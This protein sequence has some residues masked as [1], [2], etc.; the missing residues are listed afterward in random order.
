MTRSE[1]RDA[2]MRSAQTAAT[3][4]LTPATEQ[5]CIMLS[6]LIDFSGF[7]PSIGIYGDGSNPL[8]EPAAAQAIE[9][10]VNAVAMG[11][12]IRPAWTTWT[13]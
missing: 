4:G 6:A 8:S 5:Q 3:M 13:K 7:A 12:G 9:D 10:L 11:D 1:L 2:T